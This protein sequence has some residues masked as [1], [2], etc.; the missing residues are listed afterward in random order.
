MPTTPDSTADVTVLVVAYA[1]QDF[2]AAC[3][4][5]IRQQTVAPARVVI[6]DDC[7]PDG[8]VDAARSWL[9]AHPDLAARTELRPNPENLGLNP[10]LNKHLAEVT[11]TY[12]TYISADDVMLPD[13]IA[14]HLELMEESPDAALAYSDAIVVDEHGD[15]LFDTSKTEFPWPE[16]SEVRSH[17]FAELLSRNWM[18]AASLFLRTETLRSAGGYRQD[19]FYEDFELLV[20]LSR[21]H[22]FAWT[23]DALVGVR[24][25]STSLGATGFV[26]T[27]PRFIIALD[28]ALA[29]YEG[30]ER[31]LER[32]A[33]AKRWE[34]AKRAYRS[35]MGR[36]QSFRMLWASR[37]GASSPLAVAKH[38]LG[39]ALR[40]ASPR[41][42]A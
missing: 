37:H 21:D 33:A 26:G 19:L 11:T 31:E 10:T 35:D 24:R 1:H 18:P 16:D 17:P 6:A 2:V 27:S 39:W 9:S 42:T 5:S 41:R 7:S 38:L 36:R 8:T 23:D 15:T 20:R 14:R 32:T 25:L 29:H 4:E 30:A 34:L 40:S 22:R 28:A 13:R 3:L 12:F